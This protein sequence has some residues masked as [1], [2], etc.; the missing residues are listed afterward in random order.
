MP[1]KGSLLSCRWMS[2]G[3][4]YFYLVSC[5]ASGDGK[6]ACDKLTERLKGNIVLGTI[7]LK[8]PLK[9]KRE[10]DAAIAEFAARRN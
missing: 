8:S 3:F 10:T 1:L 7:N 2:A 4:M 5:S 6:G 9:N